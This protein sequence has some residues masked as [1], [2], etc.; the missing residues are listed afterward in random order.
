VTIVADLPALVLG[1]VVAPMAGVIVIM[2]VAVNLLVHPLA[3]VLVV[4]AVR[5]VALDV[6]RATDLPKV[7]AATN[8]LPASPKIVKP[9]QHLHLALFWWI[10]TYKFCRTRVAWTP[11]QNK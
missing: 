9:K 5:P 3:R 2:I 4:E 10:G 8:A 6:H 11:W 1:R 7:K